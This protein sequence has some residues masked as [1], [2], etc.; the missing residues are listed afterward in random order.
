MLAPPRQR[1]GPGHRGPAGGGKNLDRLFR[2]GALARKVNQLL[3]DPPPA[4]LPRPPGDAP[5]ADRPGKA[6][7]EGS[8]D[9]GASLA[10]AAL[11]GEEDRRRARRALARPQRVPLINKVAAGY[12]TGFTDLDYPARVADEYVFAANLDDPDAFAA[13]VVGESML[14]DYREGDIVIF[15]PL[16][17]TQDGCDCFVRL[18]PDHECTF[19][20]I[21]FEDGG[22]IRLQ[23]LNP[24]FASRIVDR[25]EVAGLYRAVQ[26]IT[27][28]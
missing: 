16:A 21:Y 14:T 3:D 13:A 17:A 2:S 26:R 12:P 19:K 1:N 9:P 15:S 23:P 10:Q 20:R 11:V 24:R 8:A 5:K 7:S 22:R 28:L 18:E 6:P 27:R 25:E 4:P